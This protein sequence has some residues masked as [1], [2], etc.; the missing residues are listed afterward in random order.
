MTRTR[1]LFLVILPVIES[2]SSCWYL[3]RVRH[4]DAFSGVMITTHCRQTR[5]R[6]P[7]R[8]AGILSLMT[9]ARAESRS[10]ALV[11]V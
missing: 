3:A 5:E 9:L 10:R 6:I 4:T 11:Q 7:A 1:P 2:T 8:D